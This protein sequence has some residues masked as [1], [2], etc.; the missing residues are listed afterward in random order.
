[1]LETHEVG[2][3]RKARGLRRWLAVP[4]LLAVSA[5]MLAGVSVAAPVV[6]ATAASAIHS[7]GVAH[8]GSAWN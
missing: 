2:Q 1:M 8:G 6:A 3:A 4:G 7:S 5:L